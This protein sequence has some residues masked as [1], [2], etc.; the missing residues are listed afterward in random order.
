MRTIRI[1][2]P[3][4][5][6]S[7]VS[8]L[9]PAIAEEE[10]ADKEIKEALASPDS[11][12]RHNVWKRLNP[13]S[14]TQYKLLLQ[15]LQ[16]FPWYDREGAI[17][18]LAKAATQK[19]LAKMF[20]DV[21]AHSS[22]GVRQGLA[23]ALCKMDDPL[24]YKDLFERLKD[25]SAF[26]RRAVVY[27][28]GITK[29]SPEKVQALIDAFQK[30]KD[31]VVRSFFVNALNDQT[32]AFQ[33]PD[34]KAWFIWWEEAKAD[35]DYQLG[36][37]D[38]D[39][40]RKAEEL[41]HK[42]K[43]R[44][45]ISVTG[46]VTLQTEE[47]GRGIAVPILILPEY[48]HSKEVMLPFLAELEETHKLFYIDL[49]EVSSFKDLKVV[50]DARIPYYPIDQLVEAFEDL[51]KATGQERF[52]IMACGLNC[53]IAMRYASLHP[54]SVSHLVLVG[55]I[56]STLAYG[57]ATDR[58]EQQGKATGDRELWHLALTRRFDGRTGESNHDKYHKDQKEP[59]PE[60]EGAALDRRNWSLYFRDDG[61]NVLGVLY[62]KK[63][64]WLGNVAI[65]DF[66]VFGE[67]KPGIPTVVI[68]GRSSLLSSVDD[69]KAI[70]DHYGGLFYIYESS[71]MM[72]FCEESEIFNKHMSLLLRER[73]SSKKKQKS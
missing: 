6:A 15:I 62:P 37:T 29:K 47:R 58:M 57:K 19:T 25:K 61:D 22:S 56:S 53:W 54:E 72:P 33:G 40:L 41:G 30:E 73:A 17:L 42:L 68:C 63:S 23:V 35:K 12:I 10:P 31:P 5:L 52:A 44:S 49:P 71:S 55:P 38:E 64:R 2:V 4:V 8:L 43:A 46:G 28:L 51:R 60:G 26:V 27:G 36:K 20:K 69:C 1:S 7:L 13:E 24:Y 45:T 9:R 70:A 21:K 39:A 16:R 67:P 50:S 48:G 59:V 32:Q 34:P 11:L 65:P 14:D 3:L 66:K 18:A